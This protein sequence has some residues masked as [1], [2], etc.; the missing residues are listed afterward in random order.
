ME[1][2]AAAKR[3]ENGK[4]RKEIHEVGHYNIF[5]SIGAAGFDWLVVFSTV[6]GIKYSITN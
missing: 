3:Y 1:G 6:R 2:I 5:G 4:R